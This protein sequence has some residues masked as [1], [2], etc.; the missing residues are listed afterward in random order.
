[1]Q[2]QQLADDITWTD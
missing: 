2:Q 1:M